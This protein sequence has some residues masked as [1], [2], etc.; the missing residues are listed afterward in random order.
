MIRKKDASTSA[1]H[2][3]STLQ[4]LHIHAVQLMLRSR[5]ILKHK[6][7]SLGSYSSTDLECT[8]RMHGTWKIP[9]NQPCNVLQGHLRQC[10]QRI[11]DCANLAKVDTRLSM[12]LL[13]FACMSKPLETSPMHTSGPYIS[14]TCADYGSGTAYHHTLTCLTFFWAHILLQEHMHV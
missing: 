9:S 8:C 13:E 2:C 7:S 11:C 3:I 6:G 4:F 5:L 1:E 10:K 14:L 12:S